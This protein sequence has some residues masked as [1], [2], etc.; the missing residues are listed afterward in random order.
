MTLLLSMFSAN[1]T[2][3][4]DVNKINFYMSPVS[5]QSGLCRLYKKYIWYLKRK[6][7]MPIGLCIAGAIGR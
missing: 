5:F 3:N 7:N 1:K 6:V 2:F 4:K